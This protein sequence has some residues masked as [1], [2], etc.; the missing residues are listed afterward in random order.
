M[1]DDI[2]EYIDNLFEDCD[3]DDSNNFIE[4]FFLISL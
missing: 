4:D 3:I 2:I 1:S